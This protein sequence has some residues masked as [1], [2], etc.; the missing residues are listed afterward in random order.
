MKN[1]Q[2]LQKWDD[3]IFF[4]SCSLLITKRSKKGTETNPWI[5]TIVNSSNPEWFKR[6]FASLKDTKKFHGVIGV[7]PTASLGL[8]F[9]SKLYFSDIF[10]WQSQ[11]RNNSSS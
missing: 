9:V 10:L 2:H 11:K 5:T 8:M 4:F 3:E 7:F 1:T 6:S